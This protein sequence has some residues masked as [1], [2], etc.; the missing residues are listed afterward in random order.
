MKKRR[1]RPPKYD[2]TEALEGALQVFWRKGLTATS[3]DDL[4]ESMKMN[5]PSIYAAF[6]DKVSIYRKAFAQFANQLG[7][8]LDAILNDG[9]PLQDAMLRFYGQALEAYLLKDE[10]LGCFATCTA[11]V[12]SLAH[13]DVQ[14]DL[15]I[16]IARIDSQ[17]E[18]R[19]L[20][21]QE[22]GDWPIDR[23]VQPTAKLLHAALQ[24]LA[25]RARGGEARETLVDFYYATVKMLC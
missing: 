16:L 17:L 5:R 12:E 14:D 3:L 25:I 10:S 13:P 21:A 2:A 22:D 4:A 23:D 7:K 24:S 11:P 9:A 1:G 19:L 8:E 18:R 6:G 15:K 20:R